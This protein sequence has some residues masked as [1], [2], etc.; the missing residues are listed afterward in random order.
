[1]DSL[2]AVE[3]RLALE[4]RLGIDVPLVSLS[5]TTTLS[6]IAARIVKNLSKAESADGG[7]IDTIIRHESGAGH[8]TLDAAAAPY[9]SD[10]EH[11][12]AAE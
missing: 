8:D 6:T 4:T 12:A 10:A 3:L 5:D 2:M 9:G 1:M 11:A 7:L